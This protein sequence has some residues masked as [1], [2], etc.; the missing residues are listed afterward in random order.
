MQIRLFNFWLHELI[1]FKLL[2]ETIDF[3]E[4]F[5]FGGEL[6]AAIDTGDSTYVLET[7]YLHV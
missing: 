1:L 2:L 7:T 5:V 3:S 4:Y 6:A